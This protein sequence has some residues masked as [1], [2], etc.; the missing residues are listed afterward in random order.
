MDAL[1]FE[2]STTSFYQLSTSKVIDIYVHYAENSEFRFSRLRRH[3][4]TGKD[5]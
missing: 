5:Y 3:L 4:K 1:P 2:N